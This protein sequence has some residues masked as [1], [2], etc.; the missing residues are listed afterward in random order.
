MGLLE[1]HSGRYDL[2]MP[3]LE[4]GAAL[5][6][7]DPWVQT[8]LARTLIARFEEPR[9]PDDAGAQLPRAR[10]AL[11]RALE[12][13]PDSAYT[14]VTL[15]RAHLLPGGDLDRASALLLRAVQLAPGREDYRLILA[16]AY[17]RQGRPRP[18]NGSTR[19]TGGRWIPGGCARPGARDA[20]RHGQ[21]ECRARRRQ[22]GSGASLE[23]RQ[24]PILRTP[25]REPAPLA[26]AG[27]SRTC[28][29]SVQERRA[30]A[31]FSDRSSVVLR[32]SCSSSIR[33][34]GACAFQRGSSTTWS[35]CR[36]G[37]TRR[38]A[39]S[40]DR[41]RRP[42]RCWPPSGPSNR[43]RPVWTAAPSRSRWLR[44]T[45]SRGRPPGRSRQLA[46]ASASMPF[47]SVKVEPTAPTTA[48]L[49][50]SPTAVRI[51]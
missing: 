6:P 18:R 37:R 11:A 35:S 7:D 25:G 12:V 23:R 30:S 3:L 43:R 16:H 2:A 33:T 31:A 20:R 51:R 19:G 46:S 49:R 27:L 44:T 14:L 10:A 24:P 50:V 36:I 5:A 22:L 1:L 34:G 41:S 29:A 4:R 9:A 32:P 38:P 13:N 39:C 40:A 47:P 17:I 45:T 42:C 26:R 48:V 28:V 8:A 21:P 15:G